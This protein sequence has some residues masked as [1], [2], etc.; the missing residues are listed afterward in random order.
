MAM[1]AESK[2]TQAGIERFSLVWLDAATNNSNEQV[3]AEQQL[4]SN[5]DHLITFTDISSCKKYLRSCDKNCRLVLIVNGGFGRELVPKIHELQQII[6]IYVFCFDKQLH[7]EWTKQFNKVKGVFTQLTDLIAAIQSEGE[8]RSLRIDEPLSISIEGRST[9]EI[10]GGFLHSQ[11]LINAL[12]HMYV[13]AT[14][15]DEIIDSWKS[16]YH[17]N[18]KEL[19]IL[20]EYKKTYSPCKA[21]WWYTRESFLYKLLNEGLRKQDIDTLFLFR[22]FIHDLCTQ[23][24]QNR[25]LS[26]VNVYRGQLMSKDELKVLKE[27]IGQLISMNSFLSTSLD[28]K[29]AIHFLKKKDTTN[30]SR[31]LFEIYADPRHSTTKP[32][33]NITTMSYFPSEGEILFMLGSIFRLHH[34]RDDNDFCIIQL[35]LC[36]NDHLGVKNI[37][38]H[39]KNQIDA[40]DG[41]LSYGNVLFQMGQVDYAEKYYERG[42]KELSSKH[43]NVVYYY[44]GLGLVKKE[45][46]DFVSSLCYFEK[47]LALYKKTGNQSSV[48]SIY[49]NIATVHSAK[50]DYKEARNSYD[51]A[52]TIYITENGQNHE[53]VAMCYNNIGAIYYQE[54]KYLDAFN[55]YEKA[56]NIWQRTLPADHSQLG[57]SYSNIGAVCLNLHDYTSALENYHRA[58]TI[59]EKTLVPQHHSIASTHQSIGLVHEHNGNLKQALIHY[60]KAA[61]IY[62]HSYPADHPN[63]IQIEQHIQRITTSN[64]VNVVHS[65]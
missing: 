35:H 20:K 21:L 45:H 4:Q 60:Q 49:N 34:V 59:K 3:E 56:V 55:F 61:A 15:V 1:L 57:V 13:S 19:Q 32:F 51:M 48:A 62:R 63:V 30:H 29:Q 23:L 42:L 58:L 6:S 37:F 9:T 38:E 2:Q 12:L 64:V 27:S 28:R 40:R 54:K 18:K 5:I 52:L 25:C 65:Q 14:A 39:M 31:V 50:G 8:R 43:A 7:E 47:A 16:R 26:P 36:S 22:F 44:H 33:A 10:N 24:D 46:G 53:D 17:G 41:F 11:L